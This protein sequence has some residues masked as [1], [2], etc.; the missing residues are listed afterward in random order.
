MTFHIHLRYILMHYTQI[1]S[2][3]Y[4]FICLWFS[5]IRVCLWIIYEISDA[6]FC[7]L[8]LYSKSHA[9][10][11]MFYKLELETKWNGK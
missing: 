1:H 7:V 5:G 3:I 6:T 11:C 4:L 10:I 2:Q 9:R 8:L